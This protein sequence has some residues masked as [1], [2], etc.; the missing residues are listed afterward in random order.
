MS[1][2][3]H[4]IK[5]KH[6]MREQGCGVYMCIRDATESSDA[7]DIQKEVAATKLKAAKKVTIIPA[8]ISEKKT[9]T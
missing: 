8:T 7:T 2:P 6:C 5:L 4:P 1:L 3:R 9:Q